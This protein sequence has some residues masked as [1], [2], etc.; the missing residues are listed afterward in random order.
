VF[1]AAVRN[2]EAGDVQQG[3]STL[4]QQYVKN[5]LLQNARTP[6][7][8]QA[9]IDTS[10]DRK[11]QELRYA[12][13][14]EKV[15]SKDEILTRYLN[16]AYFGDGAYGVG[17][18]AQHFF[19]VDVSK[20]TLEQAALLAG[21][22]QSPTRYNPVTNP[23]AAK[24]RRNEVLDR[25]SDEHDIS[26]TQATAA[27]Q[28]PITLHPPSDNSVDSCAD[29]LAPFFCDYVRTQLRGDAALGA[30]ADER[31]RRIHE[32]GLVIH[33]TLDM[34]VQQAAQ[35]AVN[36]TIN[37]D[38][39]VSATEVV[40]QPGTGNILAMAVNQVYGLDKTK[41]QTELALPTLTEFQPG[42]TFKMFTLAA[43]LE[44]GYGTSTAFY[45]PFCFETPTFP[46]DRG[47]GE[48]C[49][50]GYT[51]SDPAEA[52]IYDMSTG[53]WDSVNTFY[54]QLEEKIG[55]PA[56]VDMAKRLGIPAKDLV[57][58][59]PTKGDVT[60]GSEKMS[61]LNMASAYAT[62][63]AGGV[64][65]D[66]RFVTSATDSSDEKVDI[67]PAPNC[68]RAVS[69]GI[70][71][72][73]TSVLSG[74]ITN[75]TGGNAAIG[76]PVAGK[77]GTNDGFSSAWFIGYTP[78]LAAAVAVGDQHGAFAGKLVNVNADG[79]IWPE[80]FGGD[81]PALIFSRSMK[82][83][84]AGVPVLPLPKAD[85]KVAHGTKGGLLNTPP[86]PT[87]P[88]VTLDP[89][90]GQPLT[91]QTSGTPILPSPI[92]QPGLGQ[93]QDQGQGQVLG[94]QGGPG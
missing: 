47:P 57:K 60:I 33:T 76:R 31:D 73:V 80:V 53:T 62:I 5:V 87:A 40:I 49:R 78:Q 82:A 91:G 75:G 72:T 69:E 54:I 71:D 30:T 39:R 44:A 94:G 52:G 6:A 29:S 4:T 8:R 15:L 7:E 37:P 43:A 18:A 63:A 46:I 66:P 83:A 28:L 35:G 36:A 85:P 22:V 32:G 21:L 58:A 93:G 48:A 90:T 64:R 56:V 2:S 68:E 61:P 13:E 42:S 79:R 27:K 26:P 70:A 14:L 38:N 88:P 9:A 65:C 55:V 50:K 25:M 23:V 41:N 86:A 17:T 84:L 89:L 59:I 12:V 24:T 20:L 16:I 19:G 1:R 74:V 81:L 34:K 3:G 77:T 11:I 92:T 51:N 45:S 10:V 67:S